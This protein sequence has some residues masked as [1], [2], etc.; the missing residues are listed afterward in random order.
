MV[1]GLK[2]R[3]EGTP[4]D[5]HFIPRGFPIGADTITE[6]RTQEREELGEG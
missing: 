3:K 5:T 6:R 2:S 4:P 1:T